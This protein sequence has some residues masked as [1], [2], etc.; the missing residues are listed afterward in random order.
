MRV[1]NAEHSD[2]LPILDVAAMKHIA[3]VFDALIYY[4]QSGTD[5]AEG[6]ARGEDTPT[7]GEGGYALDN[8][9]VLYNE[10]ENDNNDQEL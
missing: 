9:F 1:H 2:S 10:N 8:A 3:H 4:K 7:G 5:A 6:A